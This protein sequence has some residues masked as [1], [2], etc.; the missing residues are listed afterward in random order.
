MP[1]YLVAV[2][3]CVYVHACVSRGGGG[4]GEG[5]EGVRFVVI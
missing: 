5:G 2:V 1:S 3:V 4:G